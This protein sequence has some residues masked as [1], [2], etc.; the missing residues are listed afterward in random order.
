M[1]SADISFSAKE[2]VTIELPP[3]IEIPPAPELI[4]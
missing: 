3:E 4:A 1:T 2:F